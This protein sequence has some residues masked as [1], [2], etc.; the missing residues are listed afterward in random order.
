MAKSVSFEEDFRIL[1]AIHR[2]RPT[3][4]RSLA[5]H[6]GMSLGKTNYLVKKLIREG[7]VNNAD[8]L[9]DG[10]RSPYVLTAKG[11]KIKTKL[12]V[13]FIKACIQEFEEFRSRLLENLLRL[14]NQ[15]MRV[16]LVFSRESV[17]KLLGH[18]V[19]TEDLDLQVMATVKH[20]CEFES[21]SG[22]SYDCILMA[23]DPQR[24]SELLKSQKITPERV[25]Y[26]E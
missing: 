1:D 3:S 23:D 26:L 18:I 17:G 5:R 8:R 11:I 22:G 10:R 2:H 25:F 12:T 9:D 4:Q 24:F 7:L 19:Q 15:G 6:C 20:P 21:L 16:L 13:S 14:Q